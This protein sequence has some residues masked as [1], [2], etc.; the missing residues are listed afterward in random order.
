MSENFVSKEVFN[1]RKRVSTD[2]KVILLEKSWH[3]IR[4]TDKLGGH[5][6]TKHL[7]PLE[8]TSFWEYIFAVKH[9]IVF[10]VQHH[11]KSYRNTS[12]QIRTNTNNLFQW[13]GI[14]INNNN[15]KDKEVKI[16]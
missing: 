8:H 16:V 11:I 5:P 7:K 13:V 2:E 15:K 1:P 9:Q 10:P 6:I 14:V 4:P 3:S 12:L